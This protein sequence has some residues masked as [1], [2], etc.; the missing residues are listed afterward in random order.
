[1]RFLVT[2]AAGFI[3]SH[4]CERLLDL[5]CEVIGI[6][7]FT[8]F[9]SR[10]VKKSN[11]EKLRENFNFSFIHENL[12]T[13]DLFSVLPGVDYVIHLAAQAGVRSSWGKDFK[14]YSDFNIL[15]TQKLLEI[16]KNFNL[17]KFVF[18]SSSSVYGDSAALPMTEGDILRPS[19]PYGVSK[20][21]AENL[22]TL[23]N[24][25]F[26]VPTISLRFFTVYGPRQ[27]P[28][29]AFHRFIRSILRNEKIEVY[30]DGEQT[31]D[32]T[33]VSDIVDAVIAAA[34]SDAVGEIVNIGG[35]STITL[36]KAIK[37]I[38]KGIGKKAEIEYLGVQRGDV[39]HTKA[40]IKKAKKLFEYSPKVK[41]PEGIINEI[42]WLKGDNLLCR[43]AQ[44]F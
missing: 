9:Y 1:M 7:S 24:K 15:V 23:Y 6:D 37:I 42:N 20:L 41:L 34:Q 40:N 36:N 13:V 30:G 8:D 38:E 43:S 5:K 14:T 16:S 3:G 33:Y 27:R 4:I 21:A 28:D 2:G 19:S 17:K 29:M 10:K 44:N 39:P 31:R 25:N 26:G 32:F 12:M 18:A 22:V 11:L 35:G